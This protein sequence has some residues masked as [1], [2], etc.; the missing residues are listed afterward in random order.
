[1]TAS[2]AKELNP[3]LPGRAV[4]IAFSIFAYI[5]LV[6]YGFPIV[7]S[8]AGTAAVLPVFVIAWHVGLGGGLIATFASISFNM[9]MLLIAGMNSME[10]PEQLAVNTLI[11]AVYGVTTGYVSQTRVDLARE[12]KRRREAERALQRANLNLEDKVHQRT[13][14][15]YRVND[16]LE[17]ELD[18]RKKAQQGLQYREAILQTLASIA[19]DTLTARRAE[20]PIP[21][22]LR[23]MGQAAKA[24]RVRLF[25]NIPSRRGLLY[26][27][28]QEWVSEPRFASQTDFQDISY[29][30]AGMSRWEKELSAGR[31]I[32]G[33]VMDFSKGEGQTLAE[34]GIHSILVVPVFAGQDWWGALSL[35]S[36]KERREW[37]R[38][39]RDA[40]HAAADMLGGHILRDADYERTLLGWAKALELRDEETEGHTQRV[41]QLTVNLA[42]KLGYDD[43][44]IIDIRRGALLHDIGKVG[45][46]DAILNKPGPLNPQEWVVMKQHPSFA[47]DMLEPIVFLNTALHIPYG[48]HERWDGSGYPRG[49]KGTRIPREARLFAVV[50]VWDALT[51]DRPYRKAWS[52][53]RAAAYL[54]ENAGKL[55]D[56][57]V[58]TVFVEM[59][60]APALN[61][62]P[63]LN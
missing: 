37:S 61:G 56:P 35:A 22:M 30:D 14:E 54:K 8:I 24:D 53:E 9:F 39:E 18:A 33:H 11:I 10:S 31:I 20:Q 7:G 5:L 41:T 36:M 44:E 46:P 27:L 57:Q 23:G 55:F 51:S 16:Q 21:N 25:Q 60:S 26:S 28:R 59:M 34:E 29:K 1:M 38:P 48:H 45:V 62:G 13:R 3:G 52:G 15:L 4:S 12:A 6:I 43:N 17:N 2:A 49:L 50:D 32:R 42:E 63:A 47:R 58:T 19:Q 40:L